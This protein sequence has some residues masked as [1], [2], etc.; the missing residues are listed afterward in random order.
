M[1]R[2]EHNKDN[3]YTQMRQG[4]PPL[5]GFCFAHRVSASGYPAVAC[6]RQVLPLV[7]E[8]VIGV[9]VAPDRFTEVLVAW[10]RREPRLRLVRMDVGE[11]PPG[12]DG[13]RWWREAYAA[14]LDACECDWV[15]RVDLDELFHEHDMPAVAGAIHVANARGAAAVTTSFREIT[16]DW[17]FAVEPAPFDQIRIWDRRKAAPGWDGSQAIPRGPVVDLTR[18]RCWH[19][20]LLLPIHLRGQ[21]LARSYAT[22]FPRI[23]TQASDPLFK[24]QLLLEQA[25]EAFAALGWRMPERLVYIGE[26]G[27][28]PRALR[29][30]PR[31]L[32]RFTHPTAQRLLDEWRTAIPG[33]EVPLPL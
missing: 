18:V 27:S 6:I 4:F 32:A 26:I 17:R 1:P 10:A 24:H 15:L 28:Y 8:L 33:T 13:V 12:S 9:S 20:D 14:A 19:L 7:R 22:H 31:W 5:S 30:M 23:R 16:A 21:K 25:P 29:A 11:I 2:S 3:G